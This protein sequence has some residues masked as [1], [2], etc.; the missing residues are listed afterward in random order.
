MNAKE[1]YRTMWNPIYDD[2]DHPQFSYKELI[3]FAEEYKE[4]CANGGKEA[5]MKAAH[6]PP[7]PM[8]RINVPMLVNFIV[9]SPLIGRRLFIGVSPVEK[10][11]RSPVSVE[12]QNFE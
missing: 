3:E 12:K 4:Y 6:W 1:F 11:V 2:T 8:A 7:Q 10:R 9:L 5:K